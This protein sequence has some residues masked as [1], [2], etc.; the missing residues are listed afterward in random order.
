VLK[1]LCATCEGQS[2]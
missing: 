1:D 2:L